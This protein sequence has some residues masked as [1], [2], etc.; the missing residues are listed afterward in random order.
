MPNAYTGTGSAT[1]GGTAGGAGL[2]QQAYDRLL[3]FA[4]RSEP[5]IRSVADKTPA[6]QSIPGSTVVLQKYVDLAQKTS[7]LSESVDPDAVALST[8]T[9]VSITLNEYGNSVLVTRAL[10]LFSLADVDPAIANIIAFNLADSIDAVAMETLRGGTNVI[11]SG[12]TATS[13][14]TVTAA[15]VI[16]SA[17]IRKAVAKLRSAKSVARKG[18]LYWAGIHPEVSHDL[19]AESSSGQGW[20]LPNQYGSSQDRIWAG[21]IGNYEGAFYIESSR[22][23]SSKS[24]GDQS[25]LAT[26]AVTV[27][28]TSAGFTFGVASSAVI[29]TRAEVGDKIS[30]TGI[31]SSA[32]IT[33]ISTTGSTT[34]ITVDVANTAAVTATTVVT[35]T[36]VTRVFNTII[37]GQQAMAQAVAEEPHVVIGPVVDKLMRHRPMGWY[38]VLGFSRYREEALYRIESGSSIAAL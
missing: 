16:N 19:R 23:F 3:E 33:A 4:L 30:G 14:A 37:C 26:T 5:L 6:R 2:V 36:P 18:S 38:G 1:L 10:E 11:Y 27:A 17:N 29:A 15:A 21:E 8:P 32:K 13:T 28:G 9:T 31:A 22:L 7:T 25:T 35:V 12:S 20:L 34:T 24:G